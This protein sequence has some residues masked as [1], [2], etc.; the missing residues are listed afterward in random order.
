LFLKRTGMD[1][2]VLRKIDDLER[3]DAMNNYFHAMT[4]AEALLQRST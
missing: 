4:I 2:M 3:D 1:E